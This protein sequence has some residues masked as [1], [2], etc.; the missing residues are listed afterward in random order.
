M[1]K[2]LKYWSIKVC[3]YTQSKTCNTY[4]HLLRQ[5]FFL[6]LRADSQLLYSR[7][8]FEHSHFRIVLKH[9]PP[10]PRSTILHPYRYIS[11]NI[12]NQITLSTAIK[13]S[14]CWPRLQMNVENPTSTGKQSLKKTPYVHTG[15]HMKISTI[16]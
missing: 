16:K 14:L 8:Y 2:N 10:V 15:I 12:N 5:E 11:N 13:S 6:W 7:Q 9:P 3:L 4:L 1:P